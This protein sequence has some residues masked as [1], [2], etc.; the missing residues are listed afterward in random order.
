MNTIDYSE[1]MPDAIDGKLIP[2]LNKMGYAAIFLDK[3]SEQ[4]V[5]YSTRIA[6]PVLE[7][8]AAY[9]ITTLA[10][11][12]AGA[13]VIAND[14]D[15][16]HLKILSQKVPTELHKHLTLY[17]G[18]FPHELNFSENSLGGILA[19]NVFH[20]LDGETI[21]LAITKLY[22]WLKPNAKLYIV[23]DTPYN[24]LLEQAIP[25]YEERVKNAVKW[26]GTMPNI[27]EYLPPKLINRVPD[28]MHFL[29]PEVLSNALIKGGFKIEEAAT[30]PRIYYPIEEQLDGRE[31]MGIIAK[32]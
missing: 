7:V 23:A 1:K 22:K 13:F 32:K 29:T 24:K 17:P 20:F 16:R 11:L 9:G 21:E 26:P 12:K 15:P 10:L 14:I 27:Q 30:F 31:G 6:G 2:T 28:F 8:G 5:K 18:H 4:F 19:S 25:D 3:Y